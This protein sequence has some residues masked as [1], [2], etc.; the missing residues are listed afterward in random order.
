MHFPETPHGP[1][2]AFDMAVVLFNNIVEV[3]DLQNLIIT[4]SCEEA[5]LV[6]TIKSGLVSAAFINV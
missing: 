5:W 4:R 1:G 6:K 3:F 2:N